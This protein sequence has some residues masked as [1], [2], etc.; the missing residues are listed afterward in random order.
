MTHRR[1][2]GRQITDKDK[3]YVEG[4][5]GRT[6]VATVTGPKSLTAAVTKTHATEGTVTSARS[7]NSTKAN[8]KRMCSTK[9]AYL[10]DLWRARCGPH[11]A[12]TA[13]VDKCTVY[14]LKVM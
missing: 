2:R 7:T 10:T 6:P 3:R 14:S 1:H 8:A 12:R 4:I 5:L 9:R 11:R 13:T